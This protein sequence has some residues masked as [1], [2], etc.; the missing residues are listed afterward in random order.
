MTSENPSVPSAPGVPGPPAGA[1]PA[2]VPGPP[3][4]PAPPTTPPAQPSAAQ[5]EPAQPFAQQAPVPQP[6]VQGG[7]PGAAPV[8]LPPAGPSG[9][10][11][12]LLTLRDLPLTVWRGDT[13]GALRLPG[14][15][16][17]RTGNGWVWWVTVL[18]GTGLLLGIVAATS[19]AK[20]VRSTAGFVDGVLDGLTGG[21]TGGYVS[22]SAAVPF[23]TLLL[24]VLSVAVA[25]F[26]VG[27]IRALTLGWTLRMRGVV[28][29]FATTADLAATA[30]GVATIPL[31][32]YTVLN[33]LPGAGIAALL[34]FVALLAYVPFTIISEGLIYVGLNRLAPSTGKSLLVPHAMLTLAAVALMILAVF[35]INLVVVGSIA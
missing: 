6:P 9:F 32:A 28:V 5:P 4:V 19:L 11:E 21:L 16:R 17:E 23:G 22:S 24:M 7:D 1:I 27:V 18:G 10:R 3:A 15:I 35:V 25:V 8:T 20:T 30:W 12:A 13:V 33:F 14:T 2:Q 26:V 31:A 34:G 29:P